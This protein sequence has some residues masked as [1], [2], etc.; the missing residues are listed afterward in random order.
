MGVITIL[1]NDA[2]NWGLVRITLDKH[3]QDRTAVAVVQVALDSLPIWAHI[4]IL[5][6]QDGDVGDWVQKSQAAIVVW[7]SGLV[8]EVEVNEAA[9]RVLVE[10]LGDLSVSWDGA[11]VLWA[12]RDLDVCYRRDTRGCIDKKKWRI[13]PGKE[14]KQI[15]RLVGHIAAQTG[16][17]EEERRQV[18]Q[19]A[20]GKVEKK[21]S[22]LRSHCNERIRERVCVCVSWVIGFVVVEL[23]VNGV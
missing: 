2:V 22:G 17:T 13:E 9:S 16:G 12:S 15:G 6:L 7:E 5:T 8:G 3:G 19:S 21:G 20:E 1:D 23:F 14:M 18:G 4:C 10:V 11:I